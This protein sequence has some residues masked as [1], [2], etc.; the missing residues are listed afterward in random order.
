MSL[1][2]VTW[3]SLGEMHHQCLVKSSIKTK[4]LNQ[5]HLVSI[6][7]CGVPFL[8]LD[9]LQETVTKHQ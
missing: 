9:V 6:V 8:Y 5:G 3:L 2:N 7:T 4:W 1:S